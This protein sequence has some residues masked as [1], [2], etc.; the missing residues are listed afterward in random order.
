MENPFNWF[1][2]RRSTELQ[3]PEPRNDDVPPPLEPV[4]VPELVDTDDSDPFVTLRRH[5]EFLV[6]NEADSPPLSPSSPRNIEVISNFIDLTQ[7]DAE[8]FG[9]PGTQKRTGLVSSNSPRDLR[10]SSSDPAGLLE[11]PAPSA[12]PAADASD[13][14]ASDDLRETVPTPDSSDGPFDLSDADHAHDEAIDQFRATRPPAPARYE[15]SFAATSERPHASS[16]PSSS[17]PRLALGARP[18]SPRSLVSPPESV[19]AEHPHA[20]PALAARLGPSGGMAP[21]ST[22]SLEHLFGRPPLRHHLPAPSPTSLFS[23]ASLVSPPM[24]GVRLGTPPRTPVSSAVESSSPLG[25]RGPSA[26]HTLTYVS[27]EFARTSRL[28]APDASRMAHAQSSQS[29]HPAQP[30]QP[31]QPLRPAQSLHPAQPLHPAQSPQPA[32][33]LQLA[34]SLQPAQP[35]GWIQ[36]VE[37][38]RLA[39]R[40]AAPLLPP[41][42]SPPLDRCRVLV[43]EVCPIVSQFS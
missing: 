6:A 25:T 39:Q 3:P 40:A 28:G 26:G 13:D 10:C 33:P 9:L 18:P 38:A 20:V 31:P 5:A 30:L 19:G 29:L 35:P 2:F 36:A 32:E 8:G 43:L 42:P 7:D 12:P 14:D 27:D 41:P 23:V 16:L 22:R 24:L 11:S 34:Q 1:P 15:R 37:L 21:R 4:V 17:G